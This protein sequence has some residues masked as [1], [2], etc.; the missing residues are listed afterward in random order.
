MY[1][2]AQLQ[3]L[4]V[5]VLPEHDLVKYEAKLSAGRVADDIT[6]LKSALFDTILVDI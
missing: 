6:T 3:I 5:L 1:M 4:E 2:V